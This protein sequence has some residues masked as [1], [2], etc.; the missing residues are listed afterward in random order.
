MSETI[1][2]LWPDEYSDREALSPLQ[3]LEAQAE[4]LAARSSQFAASVKSTQQSGLVTLEFLLSLPD[5][6]N[7]T[8]LCSLYHAADRC[9][10]VQLNAEGLGHHIANTQQ[11]FINLLAEVLRNPLVRS[12]VESLLSAAN[13][14]LA[15]Q[16]GS[17]LPQ[18]SEQQVTPQRKDA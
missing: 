16:N 4:I 9:Y 1:P 11:Q 17:P 13:A 10:P 3:V 7:T 8:R 15:Q 2:D 18:T 5:G 14:R 12:G 6:S